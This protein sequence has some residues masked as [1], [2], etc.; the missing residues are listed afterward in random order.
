[1]GKD[2][3][4]NNKD[5]CYFKEGSRGSVSS[6]CEELFSKHREADQKVISH[7]IFESERGY[8]VCVVADDSDIF[9]LLLSTA[10][11]FHSNVFFRQG[12]TSDKDGILYTEIQPL[13]DH[14]GEQVCSVLPAF[15]ILT[16]SDYTS[17]FYGKTKY[18]CFKRMVARPDSMF[19]LNSLS[20]PNANISEVSEFVLRVI[21]N[22]PKQEKSLGQ[23]RYNMLFVKQKG[24]KRK[25]A[26]TKAL[27]PD[28]TSLALHIQRVHYYHNEFR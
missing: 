13:A 24:K 19:L 23:A 2:V 7:A 15:H 3:F 28:A 17:T 12:K 9:I 6:V 20:S 10:H 26:S 21:Y 14:L 11:L 18:T 8:N 4:V 16:G 1:M 22:R 25:Y 5:V 27:P